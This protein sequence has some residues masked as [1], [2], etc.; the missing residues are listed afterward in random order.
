MGEFD[1]DGAAQKSSR[2]CEVKAM[3]M[4]RACHGLQFLGINL[5]CMFLTMGCNSAGSSAIRDEPIWG[6]A[7]YPLSVYQNQLDSYPK[8]LLDAEQY[9]WA[10]QQVEHVQ[11]SSEF[12]FTEVGI[13][14]EHIEQAEQATGRKIRVPLPS[15]EWLWS[16]SGT[17]DGWPQEWERLFKRGNSD[18]KEMLQYGPTYGEV[19]ALCGDFYEDFDSLAKAPLHEIYQL[20]PLIHSKNST[21][22]N[23]NKVTGGRFERLAKNNIK[24]FTNIEKIR[25][26]N[27]SEWKRYHLSALEAARTKQDDRAWGLSACGAHFL[28][29]AFAAGHVRVPRDKL[30][31]STSGD[32]MSLLW[33]DLD[34][35]YGLPVFN[36]LHDE[37]I[38]YGDTKMLSTDNKK[39]R[40]RTEAAILFAKMEISNA[41]ALRHRYPKPDEKT[42]FIAEKL[43]PHSKLQDNDFS[44]WRPSASWMLLSSLGGITMP[45]EEVALQ[46]AALQNIASEGPGYVTSFGDADVRAWVAQRGS[47][48]LKAIRL[49]ER[50]EMINRLL[51]YWISDNDVDAT[52]A[53]IGSI[54][55][56]EDL[57]AVITRT[58]SSVGSMKTERQKKRVLGALARSSKRLDKAGAVE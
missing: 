54:S 12:N 17:P 44:R 28:T 37:W 39:N 50:I 57:V 20:I 42:E 13:A 2:C 19:S 52:V 34:N 29:D 38:A 21:T 5:G 11:P 49:G 24:H 8:D 31:G 53:L 1:W 25:D 36:D 47:D 40:D 18:Q 32:V 7:R 46:Q 56:K 23:F 16:K 55:T 30:V 48:E 33:H 14:P 41:I 15:H 3:A 51:S 26:R 10:R 58:A 43:V 45:P 6:E 35:L 4:K 9:N 27:I 22:G